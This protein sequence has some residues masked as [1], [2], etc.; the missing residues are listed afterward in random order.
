MLPTEA[1][2]SLRPQVQSHC[3]TVGHVD[4]PVSCPQ[5][6]QLSSAAQS[7]GYSG[8]AQVLSG[9]PALSEVVPF[10]WCLAA[11][12]LTAPPPRSSHRKP[13]TPVRSAVVFNTTP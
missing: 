10:P 2:F 4:L 6:H 12:L 5:S 1:V 7:P 13:W 3:D 11:E 8:S 9:V